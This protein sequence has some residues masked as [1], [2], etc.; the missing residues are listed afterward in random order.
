MVLAGDMCICRSVSWLKAAMICPMPTFF[1]G[2]VGGGVLQ[3]I[4]GKGDG[5]VLLEMINM[6]FVL[7]N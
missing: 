6:Q 1:S 4:F 3:V 7:L 5:Y 2:L